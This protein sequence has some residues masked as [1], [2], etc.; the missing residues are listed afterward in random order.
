ML[1]CN[2]VF[3][4]TVLDETFEQTDND[5]PLKSLKCPQCKKK[6]CRSNRYNYRIKE[7]A[8]NFNRVKMMH[9]IDETSCGLRRSLQNP[10]NFEDESFEDQVY[11]YLSKRFDGLVKLRPTF[12]YLHSLQSE[13]KT[14][15]ARR[16]PPSLLENFLR[17]LHNISAGQV[18]I[19]SEILFLLRPQRNS[20]GDWAKCQFG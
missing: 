13:V 3:S 5:D 2:H 19:R 7:I 17:Q 12:K 10:S 18:D 8:L 6:V 15:N 20:S 1:P 4:V 9:S 14:L 16:G 11:T